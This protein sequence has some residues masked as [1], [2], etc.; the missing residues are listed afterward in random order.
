MTVTNFI[1]SVP[2]GIIY[3]IFANKLADVLFANA[4]TNEKYQKSIVLLLFAAVIGI[5]LAETIF[6]YNKTLQ[7]TIVKQGLII[8]AIILLIYPTLAYWNKM[9]NE[10]KL[11]DIGIILGV[12]LWYCYRNK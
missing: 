4:P 1:F 2:I 12:L 6:T 9:T 5:V 8:G 10:T 3:S 7:N 11:I